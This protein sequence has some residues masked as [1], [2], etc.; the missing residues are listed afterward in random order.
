V[1]GAAVPRRALLRGGLAALICPWTPARAATA[2]SIPDPVVDPRIPEYRRVD[3]VAG[4]IA[5]VGSSIVSNL[6]GR[7][8]AELKHV[9]RASRWRSAAAA[10]RRD[11]RPPST[12]A[13][14]S[15]R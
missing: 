14:S 6:L 4:T 7:W 3:N 12:G 8:A 11:R 2:A 9:Y 13:P 5:C 10:R 1:I 15:R